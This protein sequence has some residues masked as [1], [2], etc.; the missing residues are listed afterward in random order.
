MPIEFLRVKPN[1]YSFFLMIN[2]GSSEY[3]LEILGFTN[4]PTAVKTDFFAAID[5][6]ALLSHDNRFLFILFF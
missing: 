4:A 5:V 3:G 2:T 1:P 6:G